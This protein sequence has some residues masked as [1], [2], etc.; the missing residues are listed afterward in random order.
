MAKDGVRFNALRKRRDAL[1]H[2]DPEGI[3]DAVCVHFSDTACH[4]GGRGGV[5]RG[6]SW[7]YGR[8]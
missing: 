6:L 7:L 1:H 2:D 3:G 8:C 4:G 5:V